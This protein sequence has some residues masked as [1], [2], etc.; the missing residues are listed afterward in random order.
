MGE[1]ARIDQ[2]K[3]QQ[4]RHQRHT[5]VAQELRQL[6]LKICTHRDV[7]DTRNPATPPRGLLKYKKYVKSG[8]KSTTDIREAS[9]EYLDLHVSRDVFHE[10]LADP[11][12]KELLED[13][14]ISD[15]NHSKLFGI[16]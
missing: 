4:S 11:Y 12:V 8:Q 2:Q 14:E 3:R 9:Q 5:R 13:L 10:V 6:V 16:I 1:Y 15:A 7:L